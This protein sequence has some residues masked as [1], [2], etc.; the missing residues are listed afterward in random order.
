MAIYM[1]ISMS[2]AF[3]ALISLSFSTNISTIK[4]KQ[5]NTVLVIVSYLTLVYFSAFRGDFATDYKAYIYF[6]NHFKEFGIWEV[7]KQ[8]SWQEMGYTWLNS[9]IG[10]ISKKEIA[11]MIATSTITLLLFYIVFF[12]ESYMLWLTIILFISIGEYYPSFNMVRQTI[13]IGITFSGTTF[14]YKNSKIKYL[15]IITLAATIHNSALIMLPFIFILGKLKMT[16]KLYILLFFAFAFILFYLDPILNFISNYIYK[17]Y[18]IE[19]AYGMS[20]ISINKIIVQVGLSVFA[21]LLVKKEMLE[22]VKCRIW[23]NAVVAYLLF[24][25]LALKVK[26]FDR[27]AQYFLPYLFLLIPYII[28]KMEK[29]KKMLIVF[30]LFLVSTLYI[31]ISFSGSGYD[32]YYFY[33]SNKSISY[34]SS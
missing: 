11:I 12:K 34:K 5:I 18:I 4:K 2:T 8:K 22:D 30:S 20:P 21:L 6:F 1:F 16:K 28:Y 14:L 9:I 32:P 15:I 13:A 33:W 29:A 17:E 19:K 27:L 24:A 23:V 25:L 3:L 31:Y 26:N 10:V 7:L